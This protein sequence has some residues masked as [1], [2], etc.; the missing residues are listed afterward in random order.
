M[1][2]TVISIFLGLSAICGYAQTAY[3]ALL[4]SENNYEGTARTM[5]MGNAFTALGGDLGSVGINPAGSAVAGYSQITLTPSLTFSASTTQGVSPYSDGHLPY[6]E[7][8]M[9][10]RM[11]DFGMPNIGFTV[12]YDTNR[13]SG[14]RNFTFGFIVNK[15]A[16]WNEDVYAA[17]TN[18]T[19][20][21]MGSMAYDATISGLTGTDLGAA[22]AFDRM[23]WKPV[24]GYNSGM[25]STFGGYDD[26]FVGAS[27]VIYDN[28]DVALG[29]PLNQSYGRRVDG[30]KYDYLINMGANISDF[31]YIGANIG[32]SSLDYTYN[33][34][35]KETAVDPSDFEI[36]LSGGETIYFDEMKYKYAYSA[37]GTGYYGKIGVIVTPGGGFRIGAAI[38]TPTI[39][40]ITEEWQQSGE[41][42][43]TDG[44]YDASSSS[45][46]GRG[47]YRMV[48]PSRVNFG[49]AYALGQLGVISA[50]YEVSDYSQMRYKSSDYDRDYFESVNEEIMENFRASH[51]LRLG[52]EAKPL[53]ELAVRAGYS[54]AT[55]PER[56]FECSSDIPA[57]RNQNVSFGLGYSSQN[58]FFADL[59]V[60]RTFL[61][62]EYFMPYA[63]YMYDADGYLN[64]NAYAP[65]ILNER[66]LWKVLVTFGWRF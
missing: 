31:I 41:T 11:T 49:V 38:Q 44:K 17:G 2:K 7:R 23:P 60:R 35:F 42:S 25:I 63:D 59:A 22:G 65:E 33:E 19:T 21:F 48:S 46:Y 56:C 1:K 26:Q 52:L 64:E 10:S 15:T 61:Q 30:G 3:D 43:Y 50:D 58:S 51:M 54:M 16:G 18:S 28:G 29:G 27:E 53:P 62:D 4:F 12:N 36:A 14:I 20:S 24:V 40:T 66:S 39:N 8:Q 47:S 34:Y 9:K 13:S 57:I 32:I 55:S 6:F 45:P 5:A 37:S